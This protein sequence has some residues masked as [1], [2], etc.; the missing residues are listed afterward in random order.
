VI[1][2][3]VVAHRWGSA[4]MQETLNSETNTKHI[5]TRPSRAGAAST[6]AYARTLHTATAIYAYH[7]YKAYPRDK[8]LTL[9]IST[10]PS[11]SITFQAPSHCQQRLEGQ[12]AAD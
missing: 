4:W 2:C 9:T 8:T 10:T 5:S 12:V 3:I 7:A 1:A 11:I 6:G